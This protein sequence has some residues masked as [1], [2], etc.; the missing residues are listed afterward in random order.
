MSRRPA[1]DRS[2]VTASTPL[3]VVKLGA[4]EAST[5]AHPPEAGAVA[6]LYY[7]KD[8]DWGGV[9]K[10]KATWLT[11]A[12]AEEIAS[13]MRGRWGLLGTVELVKQDK[14]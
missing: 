5:K 3:Y 8:V 10:D 9:P 13:I 2:T 1:P 6:N 12:Q 11:K 7:S 4:V 14:E